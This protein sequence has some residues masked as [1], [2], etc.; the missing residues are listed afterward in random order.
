VYYTTDSLCGIS[1]VK[2]TVLPVEKDEHGNVIPLQSPY[3][4]MIDRGNCTFVQKVRNAQRD[5]A[6]AVLVADSTCLCRATDC[7][8][9]PE[10]LECERE[11]PIMSDDGSGADISIPSFLVFKQ[12]ADKMKLVLEKNQP[13]RAELSFSVP[14]PDSRVEYD[15]WTTPADPLAFNFLKSFESAAVELANDASFTPHMYIINGIDVG[16]RGM[17]SGENF[18]EGLCTNHGRYCATDPDD[19]LAAGIS[20]TD[21]VAESLRR[22]CIWEGYGTK[23][24]IGS[25]WWKYVEKFLDTCGNPDRLNLF[26]DKS[27]IEGAMK[28]AGVDPK[29]IDACM[30]KSGGLEG[31]DKNTLLEASMNALKKSGTFLI[32]SLYVNQAP[33]RG[34]MSYSTVFK[35]ICSGYASGYEPKIC[36]ACANCNKEEQC[37][38][39][40]VC[41]SGFDAYQTSGNANGISTGTFA[42]SM[43]GITLL[44]SIV[45][46]MVFKRQQ[47]GMRDE[48]RGI[49]A[50]YMPVG[51]YVVERRTL[52]TRIIRVYR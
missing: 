42:A 21:V 52:C 5:G 34:L 37:V 49:L 28:Y 43:L 14:S 22:M 35:A 6:A 26:S 1:P 47:Q 45:G 38:E 48:V 10:Q 50:E 9:P 13:I 20:G 17:V 39:D 24:G 4:L 2:P 25:P 46:Y 3:I 44:F 31:D 23:D 40:G 19:D 51:S 41:R 11:E 27:C 33:V 36:K 29:S 30:T 16:C 8:M 7:I 12:D 18:C 32:P 15:L